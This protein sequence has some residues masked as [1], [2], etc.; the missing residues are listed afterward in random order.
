MTERLSHREWIKLSRAEKVRRAIDRT[1]PPPSRCLLCGMGV[2]PRDHAA[3]RARCAGHREPH[4]LDTWI[5]EAEALKRLDLST[6]R[7]L[8]SSGRVRT[9]DGGYLLRDVE[10]AADAIA[11][12]E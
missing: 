1:R 6:L 4:R 2:T 7:R 3:H 5:T 12:L 11:L 9:R 10:I 8:V